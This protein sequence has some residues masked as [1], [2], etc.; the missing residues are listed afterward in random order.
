MSKRIATWAASIAA[1]GWVG[2]LEAH[3]GNTYF[4]DTSK[5]ITLEGKVVSVEWVYPHRLLVLEST[6]E[7]GESQTWVLWGS[8]NFTG[9]AAVELRDKL[10]PGI[11]IVARAFPSR[12][13]ER[14]QDSRALRYPSGAFEVG[15]GEIRFPNGEIGKF[16]SGPTF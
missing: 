16:G 6:D 5:V 13:T 2:A 9:P 15:A 3:H 8:A 4:F 10:Q 12:S 11:A 1:F 7:N 14:E